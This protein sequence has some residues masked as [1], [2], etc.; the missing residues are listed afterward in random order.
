MDMKAV[1]MK[2]MDN[3]NQV[4]KIR[5]LAKEQ[6]VEEILDRFLLSLLFPLLHLF[7]VYCH[8]P[9]LQMLMTALKIC[10]KE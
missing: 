6:E 7:L 1:M 10:H 3:M 9:L 8:V 2:G 4:L 5:A